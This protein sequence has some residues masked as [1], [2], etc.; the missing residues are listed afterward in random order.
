MA[1]LAYVVLPISGLVAF[2]T[3]STSRVRFHGLQAIVFGAVW[4]LLLYAATW[5]TPVVTQIIGA[6]GLLL[7]LILIITTALGRDLQLPFL[8][9]RLRAAAI[10]SITSDMDPTAS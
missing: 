7:W 10:A 1:A 4:P 5:T 6:A 8:G 9:E 2:L 3:G